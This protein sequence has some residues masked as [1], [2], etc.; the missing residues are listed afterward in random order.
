MK[1]LYYSAAVKLENE[2]TC[3]IGM[4]VDT[5]KEEINNEKLECLYKFMIERYFG[6]KCK[7]SAFGKV[8]KKEFETKTNLTIKTEF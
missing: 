4:K 7:I 2:I 6:R 3:V 1:K 5:V 8:N